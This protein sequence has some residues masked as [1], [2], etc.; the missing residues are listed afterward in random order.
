MDCSSLDLP[1]AKAV[2]EQL[3]KVIEKTKLD[4]CGWVE[5]H[6]ALTILIN[7]LNALREEDSAL[8]PDVYLFRESDRALVKQALGFHHYF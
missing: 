2:H 1:V 6:Y 4:D 7:S 5:I 8:K 3:V